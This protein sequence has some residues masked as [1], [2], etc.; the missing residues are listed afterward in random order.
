MQAMELENVSYVWCK[1]PQRSHI[2]IARFGKFNGRGNI[3]APFDRPAM[4][5]RFTHR[6]KAGVLVDAFW[7]ISGE[8]CGNS[9]NASRV[10]GAYV[11]VYLH[12]GYRRTARIS[13]MKIAVS[14]VVDDDEACLR[15]SCQ[16]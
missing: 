16:L 8:A 6:S 11:G 13:S 7:G 1:T 4:K 14:F 2:C 15:Q 5:H 10:H 12:D 9:S 3:V